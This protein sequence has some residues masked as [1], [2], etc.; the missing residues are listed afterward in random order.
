VDSANRNFLVLVGASA[1]L[2]GYATCG[3]IAYALVPLLSGHA[4]ASGRLAAACL[5]PAIVLALLLALSTGLGLRAFCRQASASHR[6]SRRIQTLAQPPTPELRAA[7]RRAELDGRVS[8]VDSAQ[9]FSFVYG[10]LVPRV[11]ISRGLVES[12]SRVE[13]R[14]A[15]EHERYHVRN[16]DPLKALI[17]KVLTEALFLLP[18]LAV[19]RERYEAARELAADRRAEQACGSRPLLGALLKALEGPRWREPGVSAS[20][21]GP[22]LLSVRLSRLETGRAP[23]L[24]TADISSLAWSVLGMGA[25]AA[26]VV[27]TMIGLG[28]TASLA[29]VAASELSPAGAFYGALCLAPVLAAAT[30]VYW[31]LSRRASRPLSSTQPELIRV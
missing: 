7:A 24:A 19:L 14:A 3:F 11:A 25:L 4:E 17:G 6:L 21:A 8:L 10:V 23:R 30:L 20:L 13:L 2:A 18:S 9:S 27:S 5:L 29:R 22:D 1:T 15:L 12:L 16:L 31:R 26:L 28:G